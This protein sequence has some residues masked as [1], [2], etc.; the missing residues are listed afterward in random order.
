MSVAAGALAVCGG[1]CSGVRAANVYVMSS[2]SP[3]VDNTVAAT[4]ISHG[5]TATVGVEYI[6]FDG[7]QSLAGFQ[8]VYLQ[9]NANW[10]SGDMPVAGQQALSA[11]VRG[12]GRLVTSEWTVWK[13]G[14]QGGFAVLGSVL[15]LA[16]TT[17]Y[18]GSLS[19]TLAQATPNAALNAGVP[20]SFATAMV[21]YGGTETQCPPRPGATTYYT[22]PALPGVAA[23]AGWGVGNGYVF[24]FNM[25]CGD[26]QVAE[27]NF[28][29]LLSNA[30]AA[31]APPGCY[32]NCDGSTTAP[33]LNVL[34]FTCFLQ[35]FAAAD[36][37]ANC[38]LSTT[39][40][41]LNVLDF[42]CFLQKFA[43]GCS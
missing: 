25:T 26:T 28:G 41:V 24:S 19:A 43:A 13:T 9:T 36:P 39:P 3:A 29:Q 1:V 12:G 38:D 14:S 15:P 32:P 11:W 20:N 30:M 17:L 5:H 31:T 21:S 23:L 2:G 40:P 16:P 33:V 42:T 27:A 37:Y 18:D 6:S 34:D 7:T 8:T 35:K 10:A 4:L 22:N